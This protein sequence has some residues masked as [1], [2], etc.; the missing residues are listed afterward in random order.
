MN[1][2]Q[3]GW[4]DIEAIIRPVDDGTPKSQAQLAAKSEIA[5]YVSFRSWGWIFCS[6]LVG[7]ILDRLSAHLGLHP[8]PMLLSVAALALGVILSELIRFLNIRRSK[9]YSNRKTK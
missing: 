8:R 5:R 9:R 2:L 3:G 6:Y 7:W 1:K 4:K